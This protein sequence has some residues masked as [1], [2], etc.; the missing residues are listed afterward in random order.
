MRLISFILWMLSFGFCVSSA[1]AEKVH[2]YPIS[3]WEEIELLDKAYSDENFVSSDYILGSARYVQTQ[4]TKDVY[5]K[6]I[7]Q[8]VIETTFTNGDYFAAVLRA[9]APNSQIS[10]TWDVGLKLEIILDTKDHEALSQLRTILKKEK[11]LNMTLNLDSLDAT[12]AVGTL[13]DKKSIQNVVSLLNQS[14]RTF[15]RTKASHY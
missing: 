5:N 1:H 15:I 10:H 8:Y 7:S 9:V 4:A 12:I 2:S 3:T 11:I 14:Y 13:Q 6:S